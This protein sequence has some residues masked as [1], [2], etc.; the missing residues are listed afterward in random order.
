MVQSDGLGL[1]SD[2]RIFDL[3]SLAE[4]KANISRG[5]V[6]SLNFDNISNDQIRS[7]HDFLNSIANDRS[8]S[9]NEIAEL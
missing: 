8:L 5:L 1:A 4:N 6:A 3:E 7:I 2:L 9:G